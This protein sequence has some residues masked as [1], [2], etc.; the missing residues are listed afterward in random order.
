MIAPHH[1][2]WGNLA[3][4]VSLLDSFEGCA[5]IVD[6]YKIKP[7]RLLDFILFKDVVFML[8]HSPSIDVLSRKT[9]N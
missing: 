6:T 9:L 7:D 8:S 1:V 3:L 4:E 2:V 5:Q